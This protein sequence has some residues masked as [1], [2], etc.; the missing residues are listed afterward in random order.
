MRDEGTEVEALSALHWAL[1][2]C[3]H[4]TPAYNFLWLPSALRIKSTALSLSPKALPP[5]LPRL[6][7]THS[8]AAIVM[9]S[10]N[11]GLGTC[12]SFPPPRM[13]FPTT[14]LLLA[15]AYSSFES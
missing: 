14:P 1:F 9:L 5:L 7:A 10:L 8:A 15:N 12:F 6:I 2:C 13:L 4:A 3:D 11:P